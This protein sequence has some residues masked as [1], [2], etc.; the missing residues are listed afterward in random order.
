MQVTERT[1]TDRRKHDSFGLSPSV[2]LSLLIPSPSSLVLCTPHLQIAIAD[3]GYPVSYKIVI[4]Y[5]LYSRFGYS[6]CTYI[7][8]NEYSTH[9][10]ILH[11]RRTPGRCSV[12][13]CLDAMI[14]SLAVAPQDRKSSFSLLKCGKRNT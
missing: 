14:C 7:Q 8:I 6:A 13:S 4:D 5:I 11:G 2:T 9:F 1:C 3:R 12:L 10:N